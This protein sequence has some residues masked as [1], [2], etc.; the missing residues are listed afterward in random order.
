MTPRVKASVFFAAA[1]LLAWSLAGGALA[2]N[3]RVVAIDIQ[4]VRRVGPD[5]IRQAMST[6]AGGEFDLSKIREDVKAVYRMGYFVDVK[7]DAEEVPGG[8]RLTIIVTEKPIV[9]SVKIEGNKEVES[10]DVRAAVTVKE[11][12]LF[13]ED[14]VKESTLKVLEVYQNK[15]FFDTKVDSKVEEDP[16]GSIRVAFRVTEGEKLKIVRI[17]IEGNL[18]FKEKAVLKVMD[19]KKEG[20]FSFLTESGTFKK[21]VLENDI[22]KIEALYQNAGFLDSKISNPVTK[23]GTKG[24]EVTINVFEGRQYRVG[25]IRFAGVSDI[26]EEELRKTVKL[27]QGEIFNRETLLGDLLELTTRQNDKGYAQALVSPLVEKRKDYPVADVTFKTDR[28]G[29]FHFGKV[30]ITGNVKT[31]DRII[32]RELE[33]R[34]GQ[35]YTATG[36]K[37]SKDNLNRVSYFKDIKITTTPAKTPA[38]MDVKVDIQEGPTGTLSGGAGY[39]SLDKIFGV[40]QLTENNLFGRGWKASLSTQ[41]GARRTVYQLNFRDPH[42]FDTD[43]SLL[44]SAYKTDVRYEDFRRRASGGT[45]GL[46]YQF[47]KFVGASLSLRVDET[48]ITDMG[49]AVSSILKDEFSKGWQKTHSLSTTVTRNTTDKPLDPSKGS[50]QSV[51]L[52]YAGGPLGGDS[53][54]VKYFLNAKIYRPLWAPAVI[55]ANFLWGHTVSTVGGRVPIFERYFLGGPYSIRGFK[56]RTVSPKDPNTGEL[57]GGNKELFMNVEYIVPIVAEYGFKA[58]F[59]FD[60]GNAYRQSD[61]PWEGQPLKTAA[62]AGLRWYSPM[63]PLRFEWGWNL[64][65]KPGEDKMV[66]EFTIGT[67]F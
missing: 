33:V 46:G 35:L 9:S 36:L 15:G 63:G 42:L 67:V 14:Q 45:I 16:D 51:T 41:F 4:G 18:Y 5:S 17:R 44:L 7:F 25:E 11:R 12:S 34:D 54:F 60:T 40:V 28:G 39:S 55:S 1:W 47:S 52:E 3:F 64:N 2:E 24:L 10:A 26:P 13:N 20:F 19:T 23:R 65:P 21:D 29:I 57:I 49:A 6:K 66:A 38:E 31:H 50:V 58:V 37:D 62:G 22:R 53:D 56:S 32:R 48:Q 43:Y 61:W 27:K 8:Y 30:E 59:F